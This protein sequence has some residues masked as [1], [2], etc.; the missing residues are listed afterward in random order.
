MNI[1]ELLVVTFTNAAA[2]EMRQRML[3]AIY[4]YLEEH[5]EDTKMQEQ[6]VKM[7]KASICTIHAFC[8]EVIRNHFYEIG[9][10]PNIRIGKPNEM[11]LL[12][13]QVLEE[14]F[15]EKYETE[16]KEFLLLIDTYTTYQRDDA[17]K[18][19]VLNIFNT[20]KANPFPEEWLKKAVEDFNISE[21]EDFA[22]TKWGKILLEEAKEE[23]ETCVL[24]L[25]S[26][27]KELEKYEEL[28]KFT[29]TIKQDITNL[30]N[31]KTSTMD[32]VSWDKVLEQVTNTKWGTW[33]R[34]KIE[35]IQKD[36][37]KEKRDQ[38]KK[39]YNKVKDKF[40]IASS[41]QIRQD[42]V[43]M[44][45]KL[46]CLRDLIFEFETAFAKEKLEKNVM[47]FHDI[48]HF[49]LK[50]LVKTD[51]NGEKR[52]SEVAL[53]YKEKFKE[54]AIDEYQDSNLIQEY[55]LNMI[56][57]GNNL[58]MVGDVKQSIYKF[59]Q[60][61]P[62][63]FLEKYETY[64]TKDKRRPEE[65]LKIQLFKNFRSRE[66]VLEVTNH[67]FESIMS[68]ILGEIDYNKE[69]YLNLGANFPSL[70]ED[71]KEKQSKNEKTILPVQLEENEDVKL[72]KQY[73]TSLHILNLK[74]PEEKEDE[75]LEQVENA[76]L[77]ARFVANQIQEL[78]KGKFQ[79]YDKTKGYRDICYKDI[80][81]L[82]RST[83]SVAPIFEK[84]LNNQNIPVFS[85]TGSGYFDSIEIQTMLSLLKIIDNP[86]QDI[87]FVSV[88]RSQIGKFDDNELIRIKLNGERGKKEDFYTIFRQALENENLGSELEQKMKEFLSKLEEFRNKNEYMPLDEF[89]WHIYMETGYYQYVG[90]MPNG[91]VK[92][93]NLK[94]LFERAREY[95]K[96]SFKG[97]FY[98][99]AYINQLRRASSDMDAAKII[100]ENEDVVRIMSIHK[101]KGLEFP[102]VI[103]SATSKKFNLMDL[104]APILLH[105][106]LGI[107]PKYIDEVRKIEY[108]TLQ[109]LAISA[110]VTK[111]TLSE[112]MRILYVALTRAKEK[113]IITGVR[114]DFE[115]EIA[116]KKERL[117]LGET[118]EIPPNLVKQYKS[119]LDWLELVY[120]KDEEK[121]KTMIELEVHEK[122]ELQ[123]GMENSTPTKREVHF[124]E[125][126][127]KYE[128]K[129]E[130]QKQLEWQYPY[131]SSCDI[132]TMTSVSK[133][134]EI[135]TKRDLPDLISMIEPNRIEFKKEKKV[136]EFL[137]EE[138]QIS[139]ARKGTLV[140]L[141]LQH[142]N[143]KE[144]YT[145]AKIETLI[146]TLEQK[147][148]ITKKEAEAIPTKDLLDY[149]KSDLFNKLKQAKEI[150]KE[151]PFYFDM[152]AKEIVGKEVEEP[153]LVQGIIDLYYIDKEHHMILVD[154]KTDFVKKEEDLIIKY[155]K[156]L[157]IY[158]RA[159]EEASGK[160]VD[161]VYIYSVYLQKEIMVP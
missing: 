113:L 14:L 21:K 121:A 15:E 91:Q 140:H 34:E 99:I 147:Q 1:D 154:Y 61:R 6:I 74:E 37:A 59:R 106:D 128:K 119:Y 55:I 82:L 23:I 77:E 111:E 94:M 148:I 96:A 68:K 19:L 11:E 72:K 135:E 134:K 125:E 89:I 149:T 151:T 63:L 28:S 73:K 53:S 56:S 110:K 30:E 22:N 102:V 4:A 129:K 105:Q 58:F 90:L 101:S 123:K 143:E 35:S 112:E 9:V 104:N 136:P 60:A 20:I 78:I 57:N 50:I 93:A 103:L 47:D 122:Q 26:I 16:D 38:V 43:E 145:L 71:V 41:E 118:K 150:H 18:D 79:V 124:I 141:C 133:I 138:V 39:K 116:K 76:V 88:L 126:S 45:R 155:Q 97:L 12:K 65:D 36:Q 49:A 64:Q 142:I 159:L 117:A 17:L 115:K 7:G 69:E 66:N 70:Q 2:S 87:P 67:V 10:S 81:I 13:R 33:P 62:E 32:L 3:D 144:E 51:E 98:F 5:P 42:M 80:V 8:L 131:E 52:P 146:K 46:A 107:G 92:Q 75:E 44:Y 152:Q 132:P 160:K 83:A 85:D 127:K 153:I 40:F 157:E 25:K 84:E 31:I 109:K 120:L 161:E 24:D 158:K 95:E 139:S 29:E 137:K 54:I 48:E 114:K 86:K 156:Q 27:K 130:L 108:P 100:S